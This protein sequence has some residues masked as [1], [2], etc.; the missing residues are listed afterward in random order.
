MSDERDSPA[1]RRAR[2]GRRLDQFL[3]S[4]RLLGQGRREGKS[5]PSAETWTRVCA[6][7]LAEQLAEV[8]QDGDGPPGG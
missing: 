5:G 3:E 2:L 4:V 7:R 6:E 1:A 8:V